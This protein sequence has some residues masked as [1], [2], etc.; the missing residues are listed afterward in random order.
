SAKLY[1]HAFYRQDRLDPSKPT[2]LI[3]TGGRPLP[4]WS[5]LAVYTARKDGKAYYAIVATD[6]KYQPITNVIAGRSATTEPIDER[7]APIQ[8]IKLYDSKSRGQY[9]TSTSITGQNGL[10]LHVELHGSQAQGGTAGDYGDYYLYFGTP[11]MGWRDG[12]PGVFSVQ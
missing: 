9:S 3:E 10:P 8:P 5:G 1:G 11:E 6:E 7:V 2:A 12:L 4:L